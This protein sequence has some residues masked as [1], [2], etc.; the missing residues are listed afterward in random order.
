MT[1]TNDRCPRCGSSK[2]EE[3]WCCL[4]IDAPCDCSEHSCRAPWHDAKPETDDLKARLDRA[5]AVLRG[6]ADDETF[7]NDVR[8]KARAYFEENR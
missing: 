8:A 5:E 3:R 1:A 4:G 2:R 7:A 6:I